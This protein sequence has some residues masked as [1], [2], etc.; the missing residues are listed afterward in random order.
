[1]DAVCLIEVHHTNSVWCRP[2]FFTP[3]KKRTQ[4]LCSLQSEDQPNARETK[5]LPCPI[6]LEIRSATRQDLR[7]AAAARADFPPSNHTTAGCH[8]KEISFTTT[9]VPEIYI[10][11]FFWTASAEVRKQGKE[12]SDEREPSEA[13]DALFWAEKERNKRRGR[14]STRRRRRKLG[15]SHDTPKRPRSLLL[16]RCAGDGYES[17]CVTGWIWC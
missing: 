8:S 12:S 17:G 11:S 2:T 15:T 10:F 9:A 14:M 1:M 4:Q 7:A 3:K 6:S 13:A 5:Q 16:I